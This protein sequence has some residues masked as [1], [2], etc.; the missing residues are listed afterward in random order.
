M[1]IKKIIRTFEVVK[2]YKKFSVTEF[3]VGK[4]ENGKP[5]FHYEL[6]DGRLL[7]RFNYDHFALEGEVP[8]YTRLRLEKTFEPR[9][10]EKSLSE[11]KSKIFRVERD[12][13]DPM[14]ALEVVNS[15]QYMR[16]RVYREKDTGFYLF[17]ADALFTPGE[18]IEEVK[19]VP[20][21]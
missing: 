7:T 1:P 6:S 16:L 15:L 17:V 9:E 5:I 11:S 14:A 21:S 3:S 2:D 18:N 20:L 19:P 12:D 8:T 13:Y 10:I 4:D